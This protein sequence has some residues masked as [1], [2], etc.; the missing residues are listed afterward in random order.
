MMQNEQPKYLAEEPKDLI[1][2]VDTGKSMIMISLHTFLAF[3][4]M[5]IVDISDLKALRTHFCKIKVLGN[6]NERQKIWSAGIFVFFRRHSE[7][8][9]A[10]CQHQ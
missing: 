5:V 2:A 3:S 7:E 9:H 4:A 10:C 1:L 8:S 6:L